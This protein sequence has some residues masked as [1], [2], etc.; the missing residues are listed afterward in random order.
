MSLAIYLFEKCKKKMIENIALI[1]KKLSEEDGLISANASGALVDAAKGGM[2]PLAA[3]AKNYVT[4]NADALLFA[5]LDATGLEKQMTEAFAFFQN[6]LA[7]AFMAQNNIIYRM[8]KEIAWSCMEALAAKDEK[9]VAIAESTRELYA[10][11]ASLVGAPD[12]WKDYHAH[13]REALRLVVSTQG[14]LTLVY[15]TFSRKD[16]WLTRKFDASITKLEQARDLITPKQNN[17]AVQKISEGSYKITK[18]VGTPWPDASRDK[19]A[20]KEGVAESKKRSNAVNQGFQ[21]MGHG[22]AIF[23]EGLSDNWPVPTTA[24]GWQATLAI[25][26]LSNEI[27]L[28]LQDYFQHTTKVNALVIAFKQSLGMLTS[29]MPKLL[30]DQILKRLKP[31]MARVNTLVIDMALTLNGSVT[32]I[33]GPLPGFRPNSV[34]VTVK[35]FKWV[36][37]INLI[38]QGYKT[39]PANFLG[40][41]ALDQDAK[42]K[43]S[44]IVA[45][46]ERMYPGGSIKRHKMKVGILRMSGAVEEIGDLETQML[47]FLLEANNAVISNT[48][49]KSILPLGRSILGRLELSLSADHEIYAL[50]QEWYLYPL[51]SNEILDELFNGLK[52][53][54]EATGLDR[55]LSAL[56]SGDYTALFSMKGM[57]CTA[58]GAALAVIALL[59]SCNLSKDEKGKLDELQNELNADMDL[60]NF[61]FSINFDL[62]IFK[63]IF[64]CLRLTNLGDLF[65]TKEFLCAL[66]NDAAYET[67]ALFDKMK[68]AFSFDETPNMADSIPTLNLG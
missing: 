15:N 41:L 58:V 50:M 53:M 2:G 39:I 45:K 29:G 68:D 23:G 18:A 10:A 59:K 48:V 16:Y 37:D 30:K 33:K 8:V 5:A 19:T 36:S 60:F 1:T 7:S 54:L 62:A 14:D 22:L 67:S 27:V 63:N 40:Q 44:G 32:A 49:K 57:L 38:L 66:A 21:T 31:T 4:Q 13:L 28:L 24:Q 42:N 34:N 47:A 61:N 64:D 9:L 55:A 25:G 26:R 20:L 46:L 6:A 43:Y 65:N 35:G 52:R 11:L 12:Y 17:P 51:P 56:Q 3:F